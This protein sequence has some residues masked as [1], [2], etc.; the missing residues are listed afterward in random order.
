MSCRIVWHVDVPKKIDKAGQDTQRKM[1]FDILRFANPYTPK[2][3]GNLIA[4]ATM[5]SLYNQGLIIYSAPYSHRLYYGDHFK[6][7]KTKNRWAN[8]RWIERMKKTRME[9]IERDAKNNFRK[10]MK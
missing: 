1:I 2:D 10:A 4:T 8:S 3:T 9:S 7:D 6:F 5:S